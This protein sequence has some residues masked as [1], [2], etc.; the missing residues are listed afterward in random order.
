MGEADDEGAVADR[1]GDP[2]RGSDPHVAR[3][4]DARAHRLQQRRLAVGQRPGDVADALVRAFTDRCPIYNTI[5]RTTPTEVW[6]E[7]V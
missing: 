1:A 6:G 4:E 2:V 5:A 7:A 3:G